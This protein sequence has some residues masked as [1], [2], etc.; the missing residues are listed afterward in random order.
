MVNTRRA[1]CLAKCCSSR[2][3]SCGRATRLFVG[4]LLTSLERVGVRGHSVLVIGS[5]IP[6]VEAA[7][8]A[9]GAAMVTT[10]EYGA[11]TT[12]HLSRSRSCRAL[13]LPGVL[14]GGGGAILFP[15]QGVGFKNDGLWFGCAEHQCESWDHYGGCFKVGAFLE[16][17]VALWSS[18]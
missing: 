9:S 3:P 4:P 18:G 16:P 7:C 6:W 15:L 12:D 8:L 2:W 14:A 1:S 5:E 17:C 10:L 13:D 11:I